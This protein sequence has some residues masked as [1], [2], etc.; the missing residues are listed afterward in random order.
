[1]KY[2]I[3][4]IIPIQM[5]GFMGVEFPTNAVVKDIMYKV[6]ADTGNEQYA[7]MVLSENE[8]NTRLIKK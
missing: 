6:R 4:D 8:L 2:R 3:G 5:E 1:M 7:E